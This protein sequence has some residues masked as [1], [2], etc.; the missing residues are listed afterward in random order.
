MKII[1]PQKNED[2]YFTH[3]AGKSR[4]LA[5]IFTGITGITPGNVW[6]LVCSKSGAKP[7]NLALGVP[8]Q[9]MDD[10]FLP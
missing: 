1:G 5:S 9:G 2:N 8:E 10:C 6:G 7:E 3:I 4:S